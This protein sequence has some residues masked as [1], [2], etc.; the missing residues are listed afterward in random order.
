MS[1]IDYSRLPVAAG[2]LEQRVMALE[3]AGP[4]GIPDAPRNGALHGRRIDEWLRIP[5][6]TP[7]SG[8]DWMETMLP[9]TSGSSNAMSLAYGNGLFVVSLNGL[10]DDV[11]IMTSTD[12]ITW[13]NQST[14]GDSLNWQSI[15]YGNGLFVA[16]SGSGGNNQFGSIMFSSDGI[17]WTM[18]SGQFLGYTPTV[19]YLDDSYVIT[20]R[21]VSGSTTSTIF[22]S[23]LDGNEWAQQSTLGNWIG[24]GMT[25]GQG[26]YVYPVTR[27]TNNV[28]DNSSVFTSPDLITWTQT[29][30]LGA[31][32][33]IWSDVIFAQDC[34]I[35]VAT[36]NPTDAGPYEI[37]ISSL[38]GENWD[39][40]MTTNNP[41]GSISISNIIY[42]NGVFLAPRNGTGTIFRSLD[43]V[44]WDEIP[45]GIDD[46][47]SINALVYGDSLFAYITSQGPRGISVM[48]SG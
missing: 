22:T 12:G 38:D 27:S 2:I 9:V 35:A 11:K 6:P 42:A 32:R 13:T 5:T 33:S 7:M 40:L 44:T 4:P 45:S 47:S 18:A 36:V 30:F 26:K 28:S 46:L 10:T 19:R 15:T 29:S 20:S 37:V 1:I 41:P 39:V 43:G 3:S 31:R 34:F 16:T 25:F 24:R 23:S 17:D 8:R 48:T 14:P 21:N